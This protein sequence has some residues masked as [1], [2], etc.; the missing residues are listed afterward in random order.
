MIPP[1]PAPTPCPFCTRNLEHRDGYF[2][3]PNKACSF[4]VGIRALRSPTVSPGAAADRKWP[5]ET[6]YLGKEISP[7]TQLLA[8]YQSGH[9]E[10]AGDD[11]CS[12]KL[13]K[14][15]DQLPWDLFLPPSDNP[16]H[17]TMEAK[18]RAEALGLPPPPTPKPASLT[19]EQAWAEIRDTMADSMLN[20]DQ[21][22][23]FVISIL[24]GRL[25]NPPKFGGY[26][27]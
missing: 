27:G 25:A 1:T 24:Q 19:H 15:Y 10:A 3:C 14:R 13:C 17:R 20:Q 6:L 2:T 26:N 18:R 11:E 12:C 21:K 22:R 23:A 7:F 16:Y 9:A 8:E 4:P 5:D